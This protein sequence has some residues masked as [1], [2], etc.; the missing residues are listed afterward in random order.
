LKQPQY[1]PLPVEEQVLVLYVLT[2]RYMASVR[3]ENVKETQDELL[4]HMRSS[5]SDI[6]TEIREKKAL[7]DEL[8]EKIKT[9]VS[10]FMKG[11]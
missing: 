8:V 1:S 9:V 5:H 7:D 2:N 10:E 4:D 6:L 3:V 11:R